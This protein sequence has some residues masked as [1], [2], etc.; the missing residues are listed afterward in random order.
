MA[1]LTGYVHVAAAQ[2]LPPHRC[3]RLTGVAASQGH[4][5]V[6]ASQ[7]CE[8]LASCAKG[9]PNDDVRVA[10]LAA[11]PPWAA[12]TPDGAAEAPG[13]VDVLAAAPKEAKEAL[14]RAGLRAAGAVMALRVE[15]PAP[16]HLHTS[17]LA[18]A[19][20]APC[21]AL[22]SESIAKPVLRADGVLAL[23]ALALAAPQ[24]PAAAAELERVRC[25]AQGLKGC[26]NIMC[27]SVGM[28][29]S[30]ELE[31]V[32]CEA[33]GLEGCGNIMCGKGG[34]GGGRAAGKGAL[35]GAGAGECGE[36]AHQAFGERGG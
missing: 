30:V 26:G 12:C 28:V 4:G 36:G 33:Q 25:E 2:V 3:C 15:A 17:A 5:H 14:R 20:A 9:E 35:G 1:S 22:V 7:V 31:K 8:L 34:K 19:L 6:A 11:L 18:A 13:V 16:P 27:E 21:A 32:R 10:A 24:A 29:E 23:R